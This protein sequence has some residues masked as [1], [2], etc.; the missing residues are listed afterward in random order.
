MTGRGRKTGVAPGMYGRGPRNV[1]AWPPE[2]MGV[3]PGMYGRGP[4]N[5][6]A[7]PAECTG[8]APGMYGRGRV[9]GVDGGTAGGTPETPNSLVG[10]NL[11]RH[12]PGFP[13]PAQ[14]LRFSRVIGGW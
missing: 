5:V 8:V 14:N 9:T 4:R 11:V 13:N 2:C 12:A 10:P 6:W 3:A 7:W 1:W